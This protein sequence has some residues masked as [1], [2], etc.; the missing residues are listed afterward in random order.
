MVLRKCAYSLFVD[1]KI[2]R[3]YD[4]TIEFGGWGAP[5]EEIVLPHPHKWRVRI[6]N[7]RM[8]FGKSQLHMD[9]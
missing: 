9:N 7:F 3:L 4:R 5:Y 1:Y 2:S 6:W 8:V